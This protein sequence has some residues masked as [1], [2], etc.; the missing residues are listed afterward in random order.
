MPM[1]ATY[2]PSMWTKRRY[3]ISVVLGAAIQYIV[4]PVFTCR[5]DLLKVNSLSKTSNVTVEPSSRAL[6]LL[7]NG[8]KFKS[9]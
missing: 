5:N 3:P 4:T 1:H 9:N 7:G 6:A 8:H 2:K